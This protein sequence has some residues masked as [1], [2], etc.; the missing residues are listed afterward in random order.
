ME[1]QWLSQQKVGLGTEKDADVLRETLL[2]TSPWLLGLHCCVVH[3]I[4]FI[5][6]ISLS[7]L[8]LSPVI[9]LSLHLGFRVNLPCEP[10]SYRF[11][12][13][14]PKFIHSSFY[15]TLL[16]MRCLFL[17]FLFRHHHARIYV[18][19]GLRRA[20]LQKRYPVLAKEEEY[21]RHERAEFR[22]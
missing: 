21:G 14:F 5:F 6:A 19:H 22:R 7:L 17:S 3:S 15:S 10:Q 4:S 20:R 2:E 16:H 12:R 18:A 9:S 13:S 1:D 11:L 8:Y